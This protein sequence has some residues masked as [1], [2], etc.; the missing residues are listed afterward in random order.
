M[1]HAVLSLPSP[2]VWARDLRA[3]YGTQELLHSL[4]FELRGNR[5]SVILGPGGSG[6]TTLL[7]ALRTAEQ[8][9]E[10]W[11]R[12]EVGLPAALPCLMRQKL[13][14]GESSLHQLLSEPLCQPLG[15]G[16]VDA[17]LEGCSRLPWD[18]WTRPELA[19]LLREFWRCAPRAASA[20][21]PVLDV[22]LEDLPGSLARLAV[23]TA[24]AAPEVPKVLL[25]DEP[26]VGMD[27]G[28]QEWLVL[29]LREMRGRRTVVL[30]THNLRLARAVAEYAMLLIDGEIVEAAETPRFF[31]EP[32]HPRTRHFVRMGC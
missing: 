13:R 20:L 24:L 22:P 23:F 18:G 2:D 5:V 26:E 11:H 14:P 4:S 15:C 7:R 31:D 32:V 6:K 21:L 17:C 10:L 25:L 12:G 16:V 8:P 9:A 3:G 1:T 29:K 30:V 19:G 28:H 27:E